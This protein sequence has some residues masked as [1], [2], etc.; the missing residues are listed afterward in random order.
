MAPPDVGDHPWLTE[1]VEPEPLD[2]GPVRRSWRLMTVAWIG[3]IAA[4]ML[5]SI[6]PEAGRVA[7]VLG[8]TFVLALVAR[9]V[10]LR[11]FLGRAWPWRVWSPWLFVVAA[12]LGVL[13]FA[14]VWLAEERNERNERLSGSELADWQEGCRSGGIESY[15]DLPADH[16]TRTSFTRDE[17]VSILDRFCTT[18]AEEGYATDRAPTED[19]EVELQQLMQ[20]VL[21]EME[22]EGAL[23]AT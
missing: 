15:D 3:A 22:S 19:E 16:P 1:D 8:V 17:M 6:R 2:E 21:A 13:S 11:L 23:G 10:Y 5:A 9:F 12:S 14:G 20:D 18:A 4:W 7:I